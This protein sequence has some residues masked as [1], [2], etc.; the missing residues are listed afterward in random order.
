MLERPWGN[1][2]CSYQVTLKSEASTD[3]AKM[4][5]ERGHY[6][7]PQLLFCIAPLEVTI[8]RSGVVQCNRCYYI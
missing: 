7:L 3:L 6:A 4:Y 5:C 8:D 2:V 1:V